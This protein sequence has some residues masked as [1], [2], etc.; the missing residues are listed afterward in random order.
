LASTTVLYEFFSNRE[1]KEQKQQ[2]TFAYALLPLEFGFD[3]G[4]F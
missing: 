3:S 4:V 2:D 1:K